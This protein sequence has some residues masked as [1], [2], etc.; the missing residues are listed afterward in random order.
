MTRCGL[1]ALRWVVSISRYN[2]HTKVAT[3]AFGNLIELKGNIHSARLGSK[4]QRDEVQR[5]RETAT[6]ATII[7]LGDTD[8]MC[9]TQRPDAVER[10]IRQFVESLNHVK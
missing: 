7:T 10:E 8:H 9:I 4:L 6:G 5:F 2:R 3:Y 1:S